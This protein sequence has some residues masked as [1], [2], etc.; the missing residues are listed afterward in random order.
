VALIKTHHPNTRTFLSAIV[1]HVDWFLD[2]YRQTNELSSLLHSFA[3]ASFACPPLFEGADE[4]SLRAFSSISR[5][6]QQL[7]NT[8]W[9]Y[10]TVNVKH[11]LAAP[12]SPTLVLKELSDPIVCDKLV[13]MSSSQAICNLAWALSVLCPN[14]WFQPSDRNDEASHPL[15]LSIERNIELVLKDCS[16][17]EIANLLSAFAR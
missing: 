3:K 17:Q 2:N 16:P 13:Y 10:A 15:L 5:N 14:D 8:L 4:P 11:P 12:V 1:P 6:N 7:A 9:A